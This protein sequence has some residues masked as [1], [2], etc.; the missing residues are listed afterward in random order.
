[1]ESKLLERL[2]SQLMERGMKKDQAIQ[3]ATEAL[4]KSGNLFP[5]TT[6]PTPKGIARGAMTPAQRAIDRAIKSSP[7]KHS[8]KDFTYNP[9]T[10][11]ATLKK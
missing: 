6:K 5:G 3:I 7:K 9:K 8:K 2:I 10:N 11:R 4:Q 1:M